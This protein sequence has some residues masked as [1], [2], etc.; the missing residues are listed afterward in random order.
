MSATTQLADRLAAR[1]R[2]RDAEGRAAAPPMRGAG[3]VLVAAYALLALAAAGR[4]IYQIAT[5]FERAPFAYSL[6]AAAAIVYG[7]ATAALVAGRRRLAWAA[8]CFE[9]A[10]VLAVGLVS[11]IAPELFPADAVWS[12][13]GKGYGYVP[14]VLP[15]LGLAWLESTRRVPVAGETAA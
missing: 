11:A 1:R 10:G 14:A 4:S 15:V 2:P 3:R 5:Q 13:F 9:L 6:S 8:I 12:H 7:L